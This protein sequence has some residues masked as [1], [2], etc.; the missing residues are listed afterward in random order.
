MLPINQILLGDC[1]EVL[2]SLPDNSV[3]SVV[4]DPPYGLGKV[5]DLP[6]LIQ[7]WLAGEDGRK[8]QTSGFM[9][10]DWDV[11]PSPIVW[12]EVFRVLKP[13]GYALVFAGTRTMDLMGL[14]LRLA[15]FE[16]Q[17]AIEYFG[18]SHLSWIT[19][20]GFPK[21]KSALKPSHEPI[22][23]CYKPGKRSL[24]IDECRIGVD[25]NDK[26][27]RFNEV[28]HKGNSTLLYQGG[29]KNPITYPHSAPSSGRYPSNVL[30]SHHPDCIPYGT[31]RV[32]TQ[33]GQA[34]ECTTSE[35]SKYCYGKRNKVDK[36][37]GYTDSEGYE[38]IAAY[39][40]HPSCPIA[41]L[42]AQTAQMRAGKSYKM[43]DIY[44]D[45]NNTANTSRFFLNLPP[46]APF[47]YSPKASTSDRTCGGKVENTHIT[48]KPTQLMAY[49]VRLVTPENGIVLD[50]FMGSGSTALG[51]IRENRN[52]IGVELSEE[53]RQIA[54]ERIAA[55]T[56]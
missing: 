9:G 10:K 24:N 37:V 52:Y 56:V 19:G 50:P 38:A 47:I 21:G 25:S 44:Q 5:K 29:L 3:D 49:L 26:N 6:G 40:C 18:F 41:I 32:K 8:H 31:K 30:L 35:A 14:S 28:N 11:V 20:Q 43:E 17:D 23:V 55:T 46:E 1:T 22:L 34:T 7:S 12:R 54:M 42:D 16:V 15:G 39:Q 33:W 13:G 4:T 27:L 45:G 36:A 51:C 48:V 53:Y 2:K